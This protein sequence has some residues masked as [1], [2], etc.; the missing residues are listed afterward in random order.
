MN[1]EWWNKLQYALNTN[2]EFEAL[3]KEAVDDY[4]HQVREGLGI[5]QLL[6]MIKCPTAANG[7]WSPVL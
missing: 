4:D 6:V 2:G 5:L 7:F 3:S 1:Q